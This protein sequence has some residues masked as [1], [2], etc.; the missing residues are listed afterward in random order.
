MYNAYSAQKI[1]EPHELEPLVAKL[2]AA[3]K[4]LATLNGS[5]DLLHAGHLH[6]L[7]QASTCADVLILGVNSDRSIQQYKSPNRPIIPLPYRMEMLAALGFVDYVSSFDELDPREF[8]KKVQPDVHVN[9]SE[10]GH[11]CIEAETVKAYGGKIQIVDK[12]PGLSTSEI[13]EKIVAT[14]A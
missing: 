9:G 12:I 1:V 10:Y 7:H 4:T 11:D 5:F 13:I 14:C 2:R 6:I 3:G 8:L